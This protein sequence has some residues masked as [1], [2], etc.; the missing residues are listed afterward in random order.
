ME[1]LADALADVL[2][3]ALAGALAWRTRA[4]C[5]ASGECG[6]RMRAGA[7]VRPTIGVICVLILGAT[8]GLILVGFGIGVMCANFREA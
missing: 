4:G 8:P 5:A 2:A 1:A 6:L 3:D 7:G